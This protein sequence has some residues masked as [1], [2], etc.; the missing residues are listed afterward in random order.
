MLHPS[1]FAP[2][3]R[4]TC[5]EC[6]A[7]KKLELLANKATEKRRDEEARKARNPAAGACRVKDVARLY[8]HVCEI[9]LHCYRAVGV[10]DCQN[11]FVSKEDIEQAS[12]QWDAEGI[13]YEIDTQWGA[14]PWGGAYSDSMQYPSDGAGGYLGEGYGY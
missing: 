9:P 1:N 4:T 13:A 6:V 2:K 8:G 14:M 5:A 7:R 3:S 11:D 12:N 10:A